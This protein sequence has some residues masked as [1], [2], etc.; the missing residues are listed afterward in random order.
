MARQSFAKRMRGIGKRVTKKKGKAAKLSKPLRRAIKKIV[1]GESETKYVATPGVIISS[2][3]A[4]VMPGNV[5]L[6]NVY[7]DNTIIAGGAQQTGINVIP[8]LLQGTEQNQRV[9]VKVTPLRHK[10][11]VQL[12]LNEEYM[13][14]TSNAYSV[15]CSVDWTVKFYLVTAKTIKKAD[16]FQ[17]NTATAATLL[18]RGDGSEQDWGAFASHGDLIQAN[19]PVFKDNWNVHAIK[20]VRLTKGT[21]LQAGESG[22]TLGAGNG[23]VSATNAENATGL[24]TVSFSYKLPK[25]HYTE[26]AGNADVYPNNVAPILFAVVYQTQGLPNGALAPFPDAAAQ[27]PIGF[28][29]WNEMSY[30]DT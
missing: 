11:T 19:Y 26:A 9:G 20:Y 18:M 29:V 14:Q 24:K 12:W 4:G 15:S 8:A 25:L 3:P 21:G 22:N 23:V 5:S 17:N 1:K 6:T 2:R 28:N 16:Q 10:T 13:K 30:K 7:L 27:Y